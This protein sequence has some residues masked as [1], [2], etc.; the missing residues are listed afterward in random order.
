VTAVRLQLQVALPLHLNFSVLHQL[1]PL[2]Q[3]IVSSPRLTHFEVI[4]LDKIKPELSHLTAY[5]PTKRTLEG[6]I[7]VV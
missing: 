2:S 6:S 7:F 3:Q 4:W 1:T 5:L